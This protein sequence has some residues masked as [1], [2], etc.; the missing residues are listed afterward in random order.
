M[1]L[2]IEFINEST[3]IMYSYHFVFNVVL[4]SNKINICIY[5]I[6]IYK[7]KCP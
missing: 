7:M 2:T 1:C 5:N 4:V 6:Q 3:I